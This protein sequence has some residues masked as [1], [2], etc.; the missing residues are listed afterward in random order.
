MGKAVFIGVLL[1]LI[2]CFLHGQQADIDIPGNT[3]EF[4]AVLNKARRGTSKEKGESCY[5]L[6][7]CSQNGILC[8]KNTDTAIEWYI[9]S[10]AYEYVPAWMA[11]AGIYEE[12]GD[13]FL[14]LRSYYKAALLGNRQ[15][16]N[17]LAGIFEEDEDIIAAHYLSLLYLERGDIASF[18]PVARINAGIGDIVIQMKIGEYLMDKYAGDKDKFLQGYDIYEKIAAS[19]SLRIMHDMAD[20]LGV[21]YDDTSFRRWYEKDAGETL[22]KVWSQLGMLCLE[23]TPYTK[24]DPQKAFRL[25]QKAA[26]EMDTDAM[27]GLVKCYSEGLGVEKDPGKAEYWNDMIDE[28]DDFGFFPFFIF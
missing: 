18:M 22:T 4:E 26:A 8:G 2:P 6:G 9:M 23:G 27:R 15:A 1:F 19:D 25:L 28:Y 13:A 7:Y 17:E 10:G 12:K 16:E 3:S 21:A 11:L 5:V 24:P 20:K 14:S